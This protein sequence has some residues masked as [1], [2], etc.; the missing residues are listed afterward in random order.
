MQIC[1]E[2]L[3]HFSQNSNCSDVKTVS[4]CLKKRRA[5]RSLWQ[6]Q[7]NIQNSRRERERD[8]GVFIDNSVITA[9][10][11]W[12][13]GGMK[14]RRRNWRTRNTE[15]LKRDE[16]E[17][18]MLTELQKRSAR[19]STHRKRRE[20]E[21]HKDESACVLLRLDVWEC[22]GWKGCEKWY[23]DVGIWKYQESRLQ[24]WNSPF[25]RLTQCFTS[26][27]DPDHSS[28]D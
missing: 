24:C 25:V 4:S 2:I 18:T 1:S 16:E 10:V 27:S 7:K 14:T 15:S 21:R 28:S 12:R 8:E 5:N 22:Y 9:S 23:H 11:D 20:A 19:E 17:E 13:T 3:K 26:Q 6:K